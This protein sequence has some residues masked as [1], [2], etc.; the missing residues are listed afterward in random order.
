[1]QRTFAIGG[2]LTV[3]RLGFGASR[4]TG[5]GVWGEPDDTAKARRV[6]ASLADLGINFIDTAEIYGPHVSERLIG[7]TLATSGMVIATKG[8]VTRS[9]P[10]E[11]PVVAPAETIRDSVLSSLRLLRRDRIDLWQLHR[12]DRN[13]GRVAQFEA[14]A[15]L[16]REGLIRHV[17]LSEASVEDIEAARVYFPVVTVQNRYNLLQRAHEPVLEYCE[18]HGIGFLPWSPLGGEGLDVRRCGAV[19]T[20]AR[21]Y[22]ATPSQI[23]LAWLLK[24][25]PVVIP[26]PSTATLAHLAL[27]AL[28]ADIALDDDDFDDL[29]NAT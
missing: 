1:M 18:R 26:I 5:P 16:V 7:E 20:V 2:D 8:G 12:L 25:S 23:A 22:D 27:N 3:A 21:K 28:A 19:E 29:S 11:R 15:E 24:R 6:L 4:I 17:G 13:G 14:I 9:G 10:G